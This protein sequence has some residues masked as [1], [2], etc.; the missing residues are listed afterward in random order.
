MGAL[1]HGTFRV[2]MLSEPDADLLM[3]P[4]IDLVMATWPILMTGIWSALQQGALQQVIRFSESTGRS[5]EVAPWKKQLAELDT[6]APLS[7]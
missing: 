1:H 6:P 5:A 7:R 3:D 2:S 4:C